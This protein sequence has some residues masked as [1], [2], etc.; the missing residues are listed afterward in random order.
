[1]NDEMISIIG[2]SYLQPIIDLLEK[3]QHHDNGKE[4]SVMA[5]CCPNGY[6]AS[7]CLLSVV[8]LESYVMRCRYIHGVI[9]KELNKT[10]VVDFIKQKY[11]DYPHKSITTEIF[12]V[13]DLIAHNHL[14]KISYSMIDGGMTSNGI[15]RFSSGDKKFKVYVDR[16]TEKTLGL[17]LNTNPIKI[18][19]NDAVK[20]L[21]VVWDNLI[22]LENKD[23][24]QCYVS[25][26]L[27]KYEGKHIKFSDVLKILNQQTAE[28]GVQ[29]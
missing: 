1:M 11:A 13:R 24:R 4:D 17:K 21:N 25:H 14:L 15:K 12:V 9:D 16:V 19:F 3:L 8:L 20:V 18:C 27:I 2:S 23:R 28:F 6:A 29:K 7:I 5:G 10:S 26:L 22:F